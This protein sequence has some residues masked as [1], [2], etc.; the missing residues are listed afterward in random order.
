MIR[1]MCS[2]NSVRVSDT[3]MI[4]YHIVV[5]SRFSAIVVMVVL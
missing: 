4:G 1:A 2:L 5:Y 3:T